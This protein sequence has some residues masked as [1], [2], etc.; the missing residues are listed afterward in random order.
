M[1][2]EEQKEFKELQRDLLMARN[3][4]EQRIIQAKIEELKQ[5][6]EERYHA[7]L[8]KKEQSAAKTN[9]SN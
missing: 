6:A 2:E 3:L 4:R 8:A 5:T 9:L 1:N 7:Y